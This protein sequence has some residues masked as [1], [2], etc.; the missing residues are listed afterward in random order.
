MKSLLVFL[1]LLLAA[2]TVPLPQSQSAEAPRPSTIIIVH[3]LYANAGHVAPLKQGLESKGFTCFAPELQPND[4]SVSIET[5][6]QELDSYLAANVPPDAPLQFVG[7]S[8]GGLVAL[9]YLQTP[10]HAARC[11]GLST[12][13][14]PHQG[15]FLAAFHVGPAGR[16]MTTNS[17]FLKKL[18]SRPPPF[19]VTTYRSTNDLVIIP[20][21]SSK[22]PYADNQLIESSSHNEILQS[23]RLLSE[24]TNSI[25]ARDKRAF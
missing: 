10:Q 8:M 25:K 1:T 6:A 15:T 20:N 2:C 16:E 23:P 11:R 14:T 17:S 18:N 12:I 22:L 21:S 4:G 3:G 13:A 5:L 24:L 9:Q 19:P 7:H